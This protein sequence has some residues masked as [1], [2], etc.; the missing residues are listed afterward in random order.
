M[1]IESGINHLHYP[2]K[3]LLYDIPANPFLFDRS[4]KLDAA[5]HA[6]T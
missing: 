1:K 4:E 5:M 2:A 6:S 3:A